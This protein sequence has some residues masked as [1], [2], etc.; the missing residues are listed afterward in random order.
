MSFR[1]SGLSP[2]PFRHLFGLSDDDLARHGAQR[3][4]AKTKPGFPD[5]IELRDAEPGESL[6]LVNYTHQP[7]DSPY[8]ASHAIFLNESAKAAYDRIDEVPEVLHLRVISLRAF[9][10][11]DFL[12][13]ADLAQG[14]AIETEIRRLF[15]NPRV[16]Y[17]QAH[18]AKPGCFAARVDR[19]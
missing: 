14:D 10:A 1:I 13:D 4:I 2:E 3:Y 7:A 15:D 5:R 9:D 11:D 16:D 19:C 12:I 17:I 8:R 18:Y 6:I